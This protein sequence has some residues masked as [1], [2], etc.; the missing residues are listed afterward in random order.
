MGFLKK[1]F[2]QKNKEKQTDDASKETNSPTFFS[3]ATMSLDDLGK[4]K[5]GDTIQLG[6]PKKNKETFELKWIEPN[7]NPFKVKI[8]DCREYAINRLSTT[9]NQE[10]A[11]KFLETRKS[12]G[13]EYIGKFPNNGAKIEVDLNFHSQVASKFKNGIPDGILFKAQTMEEKWD[14]YKYS[15][16]IFYVRSWTGELVYFSNYIPTATGFK[17]DLI[18]L[19]DSKIDDDD[20]YFELKV[21]EFLIHSHILGLQVPHP[22]PLKLENKPETIAAYSFSMFGN[23]GYFAAYD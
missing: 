2:G 22:I 23:R 8:F 21:V 12:N 5:V 10:I 17:V 14:I 19:D 4:L 7:D 11:T 1:L 9:Q 18:V 13:T 15:N 3:A 16:F 6:N 20:P